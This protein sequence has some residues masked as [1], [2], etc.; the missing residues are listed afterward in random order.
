[1][2]AVTKLL[3][4]VDLLDQAVDALVEWYDDFLAGRKPT[5]QRLRRTSSVLRPAAHLGVLDPDVLCLLDQTDH[6][7]ALSTLTTL[8]RVRSA[9]CNWHPTIGAE[10]AAALRHQPWSIRVDQSPLQG[11]NRGLR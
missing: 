4:Q 3:P 8:E 7:L 2:T 10:S 5:E 1:M 9:R 6:P 11:K